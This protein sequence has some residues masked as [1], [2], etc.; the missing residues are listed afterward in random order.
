MLVGGETDNKEETKGNVKLWQDYEDTK[1][2][3]GMAHGAES[4]FTRGQQSAGASSDTLWRADYM[5]IFPTPVKLNKS[6]PPLH[7]SRLVV[8]HLAGHHGVRNSMQTLG[9]RTLGTGVN[10]VIT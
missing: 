5:Q 7:Q 1:L 3:E 2:D 10:L 6:G 8:K 9:D 4:Y